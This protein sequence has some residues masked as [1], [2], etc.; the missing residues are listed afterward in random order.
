[1]R[2]LTIPLLLLLLLSLFRVQATDEGGQSVN[3]GGFEEGLKGWASFSYCRQLPLDGAVTSYRSYSGRHSLFT[4]CGTGGE[5]CFGVG[6]GARQQILLSNA[7]NLRLSYWIYLFGV[8]ANAWA[9]IA[10]ITD[11]QFSQNK[12]TIVY[13]AAWADNIPI[14]QDFPLP[15][16]SSKY[17]SNVLLYDLAFDKWNHVERDLTA[18]FEKAFPEVDPLT[19]QNI[20][21]TLLAVTFQRLSLTSKGAFWD[22]VHLTYNRTPV[23]APPPINSPEQLTQR[24]TRTD[25]KDSAA[26]SATAENSGT[27]SIMLI[28]IVVALSTVGAF[29]LERKRSGSSS[30]R[31][32]A[33]AIYWE[34]P[35]L[36]QYLDLSSISVPQLMQNFLASVFLAVLVFFPFL[37]WSKIVKI[38][39]TMMPYIIPLNNAMTR[40]VAGIPI[41]G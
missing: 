7:S 35:H 9:E 32:P 12:K 15:R 17:I 31:N 38:S 23:S 34:A 33:R 27:S 16:M 39:Q 25:Q 2:M 5:H 30:G 6:G 28:V 40:F 13:Y 19:V 14:Y 8:Q 26:V 10:L 4:E 1:M 3:N 29:L 22:D 11:F 41:T 21:I 18:D 24:P 37:L 20:T 36:E